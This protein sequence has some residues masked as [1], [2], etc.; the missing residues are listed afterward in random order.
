MEGR[1]IE[2]Y[3][4]Q[5]HTKKGEHKNVDKRMHGYVCPQEM[6]TYDLH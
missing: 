3:K 6:K 2:R 4:V 1:N 5:S